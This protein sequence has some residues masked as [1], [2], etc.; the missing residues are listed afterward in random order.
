MLS[1]VAF[2]TG[3]LFMG[4]QSDAELC[5][6]GQQTLVGQTTYDVIYSLGYTMSGPAYS[7]D[8][9]VVQVDEASGNVQCMRGESTAID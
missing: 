7:A 3:V 4:L 1:Q 8:S 6:T 2:E 9:F 5:I